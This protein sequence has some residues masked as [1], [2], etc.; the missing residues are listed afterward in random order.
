MTHRQHRLCLVVLLVASFSL[1][2]G[3]CAVTT[4]LGEM[5]SSYRE[6]TTAAQRLLTHHTILSPLVP[7]SVIG[8]PSALLPPLYT[9]I[10]AT[11]Y[12]LTGIESFWST[13]IL[14]SVNALASTIVVLLVYLISHRI[15]GRARFGWLAAI[16]ATMNPTMIGFTDYIWDTSLFTLGVTLTVWMALNL[17]DQSFHWLRWSCFGLWLG[18]LALLNPALTVTYPLLV[19]WPL[20]RTGNMRL[21][22]VFRAVI[23]CVGGWLI[24]IAPWTMRNYVQFDTFMYVRSG[25]GLEFWLG[26]CPEA[27]AFGA[28]VYNAQ[29]PLNNPEIQAHLAQIGENAFINES[30]SR[31]VDAIKTDPIRYLRLSAIRI[32][33]YW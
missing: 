8:E 11:V 32:V 10:V 19:L 12:W 13:F 2:I 7:M 14:K 31:A 4:G 24:A 30:G 6:Y 33:D 28:E 18:L 3:Y 26:V 27:D 23:F 17:S 25:L 1:R 29:Y 21:R 15:T 16:I 5:G 20:H 22:V 9:S